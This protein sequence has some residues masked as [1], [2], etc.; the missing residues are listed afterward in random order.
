MKLDDI[1]NLF[2]TFISENIIEINF[3]QIENKSYPIIE[4]I[5]EIT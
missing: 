4:I 5:C 2:L 1:L 3:K